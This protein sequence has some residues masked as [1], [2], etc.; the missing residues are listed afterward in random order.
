MSVKELISDALFDCY[1]GY[2][3]ETIADLR[4][5]SMYER[6]AQAE[7]VLQ[8][9]DANGYEIVRKDGKK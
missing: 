4:Q 5:R 6:N 1:R 9:L 7:R 8:S 3:A 2:N